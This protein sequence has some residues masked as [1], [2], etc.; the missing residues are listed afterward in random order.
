MH[1]FPCYHTKVAS[2]PS[3]S[4]P[5]LEVKLELAVDLPLKLKVSFQGRL[6]TWP[7]L[8]FLQQ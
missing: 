3:N 4:I 5:A 8:G 6:P 2:A 1:S 7:F